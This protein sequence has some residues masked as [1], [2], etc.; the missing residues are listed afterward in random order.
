MIKGFSYFLP[1]TM[2]LG[3]VLSACQPAAP[4]TIK[5]G[6]NVELT[7][8]IPVVGESSKNAAELAVKEVND[9]GG[10]DV[11]GTKYTIELLVEDNEDKAES[12][13]A[14]AQKLATSGVLAMIGPMPAAMPSQLQKLPKAAR[15]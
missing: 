11:G 7:G 14:V 12:A 2:L 10:L 3:M 15:C 5:I 8:S 6:L 4:T 13:A 9:A 1:V